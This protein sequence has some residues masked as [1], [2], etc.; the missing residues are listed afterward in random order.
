[1]HHGPEAELHLSELSH[2]NLWAHFAMHMQ[3]QLIGIR[4]ADR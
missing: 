1:M 3:Q 2:V 4:N